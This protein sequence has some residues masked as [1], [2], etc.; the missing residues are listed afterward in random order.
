MHPRVST[1]S[2]RVQ[3]SV[4]EH[5]FLPSVSLPNLVTQPAG[6][7]A[8]L[9]NLWSSKCHMRCRCELRSLHDC[10]TISH[11]LGIEQLH[12]A[13]KLVSVSRPYTC[14]SSCHLLCVRSLSNLGIA[15]GCLLELC[16]AL[17]GWCLHERLCRCHATL[18][19]MSL[20]S[21][22]VRLQ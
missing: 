16:A 13:Q 7:G 9:K 22:T 5:T 21:H 10:G 14:V 20:R 6:G 1:T 15:P 8:V 11:T 18:L 3:D 2:F 19:L 4:H 17:C 12:A